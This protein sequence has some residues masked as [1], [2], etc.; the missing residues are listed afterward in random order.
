M[1]TPIATVAVL[2]LQMLGF[3]MPS[4]QKDTGNEHSESKHAE[5]S[6]LEIAAQR[7]AQ[8]VTCLADGRV[9]KLNELKP[10]LAKEV[11]ALKFEPLSAQLIA[12]ILDSRMFPSLVELDLSGCQIEILPQ[13]I[14]GY[15][16]LSRVCASNC[17]LK[18]AEILFDCPSLTHLLVDDNKLV[19]LDGLQRA[20][21]LTCLD[22]SNNPIH[23]ISSLT[24]FCTVRS[25]P[26][27]SSQ[28]QVMSCITLFLTPLVS[29]N[30]RELREL[31]KRT[32]VTF[33]LD[34]HDLGGCDCSSEFVHWE[35]K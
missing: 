31:D 5:S 33:E 11:H 1:K 25:L 3:C 28:D 35:A 10:P 16:E 2:A 19:D 12:P 32:A 7:E 21:R 15:Q 14:A 27:T 23:D 34:L 18:S 22:V 26:S 13:S 30:L 8:W 17:S 24:E 6:L 4:C 29:Q 20:K 9:V